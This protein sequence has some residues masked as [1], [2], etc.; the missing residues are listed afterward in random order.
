MSRWRLLLTPEAVRLDVWPL[1]RGER[2][3]AV[4]LAREPRFEGLEDNAV[5][6]AIA[7]TEHVRVRRSLHR[8]NAAIALALFAAG[9]GVGIVFRFFP[10][11]LLLGLF[12]GAVYT[13]MQARPRLEAIAHFFHGPG[14]LA[15]DLAMAGLPIRDWSVAMWGRATVIQMVW[16]VLAF[17]TLLLV[18]V[19]GGAMRFMEVWSADPE[20]SFLLCLGTFAHV[21]FIG[22]YHARLRYSP[23]VELPTVVFQPLVFR[24]A[25]R[26]LRRIPPQIDQARMVLITQLWLFGLIG[27]VSGLEG[28]FDPRRSVV[29]ALRS[30]LVSGSE[31]VSIALFPPVWLAPG[32]LLGSLAGMLWGRRCRGRAQARLERLD[33]E[34]AKL[35]ACLRERGE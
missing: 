12:A 21:L 25:L 33:L 11:T 32:F 5:Y 15:K 22:W 27:L 7:C 35:L 19:M 1:R 6:R 23:W 14:P 31:F 10:A 13:Q 2:P 17:D 9:I 20:L 24:H 8:Y 34:M 16:F 4:I 29:P 26:W 30:A 28:L 18:A 3:R